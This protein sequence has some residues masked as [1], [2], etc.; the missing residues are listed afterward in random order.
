MNK[1]KKFQQMVTNVGCELFALLPQNKS[2]YASAWCDYNENFDVVYYFS[3]GY[4]GNPADYKRSFA[5]AD[6]LYKEMKSFAD[7]RSWNIP[8]YE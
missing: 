3:A 5:T 7:F 4:E 2:R 6:E 1:S 8:K